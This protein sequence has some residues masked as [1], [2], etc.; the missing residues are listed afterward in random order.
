MALIIQIV[1]IQVERQYTLKS[2]E[3]QNEDLIKSRASKSE[4]ASKIVY[5]IAMFFMAI[6]SIW[7]VIYTGIQSQRR[8][9]LDVEIDCNL[10]AYDTSFTYDY[11]LE[12]GDIVED[13]LNK[14]NLNYSKDDILNYFNHDIEIETIFNGEREGWIGW[15]AGDGGSACYLDPWGMGDM[16]DKLYIRITIK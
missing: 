5:L 16:V 1:Q 15:G 11:S 14:F 3:N 12:L 4:V 2:A 8:R 10:N 7:T 9:F 13:W 6:A